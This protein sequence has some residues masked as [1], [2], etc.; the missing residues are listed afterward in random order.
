[1][2]WENSDW[3]KEENFDIYTKEEQKEKNNFNIS[4]LIHDNDGKLIAVS[5]IGLLKQLH[6]IILLVRI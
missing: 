1:M 6:C 2:N 4:D 5:N 3:Q